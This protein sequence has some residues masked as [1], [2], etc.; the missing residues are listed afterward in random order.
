M[1][2]P[3][4]SRPA[5]RYPGRTLTRNASTYHATCHPVE[6]AELALLD[7][8]DYL[9]QMPSDLPI[10]QLRCFPSRP[11]TDRQG[12]YNPNYP[13]SPRSLPRTVLHGIIALECKGHTRAA[14]VVTAGLLDAQE[15]NL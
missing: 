6:L 5:A 13:D 7:C 9:G 8:Q 11:V 1:T 3:F 4:D 2:S 12:L 14:A 10:S 15:L